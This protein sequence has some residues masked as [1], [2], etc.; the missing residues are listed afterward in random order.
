MAWVAD[1]EEE[2]WKWAEEHDDPPLITGHL[3]KLFS[4][5]AEDIHEQGARAEA[6]A[7]EGVE[8]SRIVLK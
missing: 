3:I 8:N 4:V 6:F 7:V 5:F 2:Y 1:A